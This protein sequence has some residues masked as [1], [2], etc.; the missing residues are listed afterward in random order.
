MEKSEHY[1]VLLLLVF[2]SYSKYIKYNFNTSHYC[3]T[4][5]LAVSCMLLVNSAIQRTH[6]ITKSEVENQRWL[7]ANLI[8]CWI[9]V[10]V[11]Q[12][13]HFARFLGHH[14]VFSTSGLVIEYSECIH[15]IAEPQNVELLLECCTCLI[16]KLRLML[17]C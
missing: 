10:S 9:L 11:C 2:Y 5:F 3:K 17:I 1:C 6:Y 12:D 8:S 16:Q 14:F 7:P 13:R 15:W 4:N